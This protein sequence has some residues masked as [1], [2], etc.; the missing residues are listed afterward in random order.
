MRGLG[1]PTTALPLAPGGFCPTLTVPCP[2]GTVNSTDANN[3]PNYP[4]V[5]SATTTTAT[6]TNPIVSFF[7]QTDP[8]FGLP[9]WVWALG[10]GAV[11]YGMKK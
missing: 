6:S 9:Y 4:C 11:A 2:S 1:Q 10:I 3:C 8:W 7:T 5:A